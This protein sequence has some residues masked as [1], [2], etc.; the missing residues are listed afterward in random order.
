[1]NT[2]SDPP[3]TAALQAAP[4]ALPLVCT[5]LPTYNE[6]K[7]VGP[8]IERLM[9]HAVTPHM[10]IVVDDNSPDGT[11]AV[12]KAL[13]ARYN[14]AGQRR[15][16]LYPRIG[17]KGLTSAIQRGIDIALYT[18]NADIVTWMDCDLSMPPEDVPRL[19]ACIRNQGADIAVGSRWAPGGADEAHGPMGRTLSL[20]IN[21]FAMLRLGMDVRDYTS[22]FIAVRAPVLRQLRLRGDYGEYCI[23]LLGRALQRGFDVRE[24]PYRC[25]PR[26]SGES[27]TGDS[28]WDYLVKGRKYVRT[29]I[30]V[31]NA[32]DSDS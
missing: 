9:E 30:R 2:T 27:K 20:I 3:P 21:G 22:G 1:M 14:Q 19:V 25:L 6:S 31:S 26:H 32:S 4:L 28:F 8:L 24:V 10:V 16:V 11:A 12:V 18:F 13:A 29:I 23:D 7:N 5:V 17:I 15:V